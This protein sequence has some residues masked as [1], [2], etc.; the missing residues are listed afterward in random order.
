MRSALIFIYFSLFMISTGVFQQKTNQEILPYEPPTVVSASEAVYPITSVASGTVVLEATLDE[1]GAITNVRVV[2]GIPSL[3][4]EAVRALRRWKFQ[5]ARL[6][7]HSIASKIP[8][9][10]VFVPPSFGPRR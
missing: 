7:N 1:G 3:T 5:P 6:N 4:E 2:R 10:F 8:V 9:G